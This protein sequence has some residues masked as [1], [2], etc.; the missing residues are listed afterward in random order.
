MSPLM[1]YIDAGASCD[2]EH[3]PL[4]PRPLVKLRVRS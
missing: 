4:D 1:G 3:A 2:A